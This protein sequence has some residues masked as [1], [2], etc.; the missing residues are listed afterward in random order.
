M[1]NPVLFLR[2]IFSWDSKKFSECL[3]IAQGSFLTVTSN[4]FAEF[5]L[6]RLESLQSL[7][8]ESCFRN[9]ELLEL[10][11]FPHTKCLCFPWLESW[12]ISLQD[13]WNWLLAL[14]APCLYGKTSSC[15]V[16][17]KPLSILPQK[18]LFRSKFP[19]WCL[20]FQYH[21][22]VCLLTH[23]HHQKA[24]LPSHKFRTT[25]FGVISVTFR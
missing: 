2:Y 16:R 11:Q 7:P 12:I 24:N 21:I 14:V 8:K 20:Y 19:K 15:K 25:R 5:R 10:L 22:F 4:M 1:L 3:V 13:G 9:T 6:L 18:K 17:K 23:S